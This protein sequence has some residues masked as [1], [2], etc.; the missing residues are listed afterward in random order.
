MTA[1]PAS[2]PDR[3]Q[4]VQT[5]LSARKL[6]RTLTSVAPPRPSE[7]APFLVPGLSEGLNGGIPRGQV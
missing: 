1:L 5:L 4:T 7:A 6:D 3:L 2:A